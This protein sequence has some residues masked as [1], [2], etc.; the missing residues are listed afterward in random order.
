MPGQSFIDE[1]ANK[2]KRGCQKTI[3]IL[4]PDYNQC[5]WCNFEARLAHHKNPGEVGV[6]MRGGRG[7]VMFVCSRSAFVLNMQANICGEPHKC[8]SM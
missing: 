5:A 3:V 1:I 8:L 2:I 6:V 7:R 4:S